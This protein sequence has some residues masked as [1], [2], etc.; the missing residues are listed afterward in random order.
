MRDL[1][2]RLSPVAAQRHQARLFGGK[3]SQHPEH[4][5]FRLAPPAQL[6]NRSPTPRVAR[7]FA[8]PHQ[9]HQRP[10]RRRLL[11]R[12]ELVA[13]RLRLAGQRT[14]DAAHFSQRLAGLLACVHALPNVRQRKLKQRQRAFVAPSLIEQ[15]LDRRIVDRLA[16]LCG[17][18][19]DGLAQLVAV[20][21]RHDDFLRAN[22]AM[23]LDV[24]AVRLTQEVAAQRQHDRH[25]TAARGGGVK[26]DTDEG[27]ALVLVAAQRVDL[28]KLIDQH[29]KRRPLDAGPTRRPLAEPIEFAAPIGLAQKVGQ[30]P[31]RR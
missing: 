13:D 4:T 21:R 27:L 7:A 24:M 26:Q 9:A 18:L 28:F 14:A 20:H 29:D 30:V 11:A 10:L 23:E 19:C 16:G 15:Q 8:E 6:R 2:Q 12:I 5:R 3:F 31:L 22:Q 25:M 1:G 17:G